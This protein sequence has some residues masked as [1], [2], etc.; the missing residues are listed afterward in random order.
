V[1]AYAVTDWATHFETAGS[2][3]LE[4]VLWVP[5]P[6]RHD[7]GTYLAMMDEP[8]SAI[9]LAS[10]LLIVQVGSRCPNRGF[11]VKDSGV[12]HDARS[13]AARTRGKVEWFERAFVYFLKVGWLEEIQTE[14]GPDGRMRAQGAQEP[15]RA[16]GARPRVSPEE[17]LQL[18]L[19]SSTAP[20]R[21]AIVGFARTNA[22]PVAAAEAFFAHFAALGWNDK[23]GRPIKSWRGRLRRWV[24][25]WQ[26]RENSEREQA[27]AA[28]P[29]P[30]AMPRPVRAAPPPPEPTTPI[31]PEAAAAIAQMREAVR[32]AGRKATACSSAS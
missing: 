2:Q 6:N 22:L 3:A 19:V 13:L 25:D 20:S 5:M 18:P 32:M 26:A 28:P 29:F 11:L 30:R 16:T 31:D 8:D 12:P 14:L 9:L 10:W 7:G 23:F 1:K 17:P 4:K 21:A 15:R 24:T 27:G